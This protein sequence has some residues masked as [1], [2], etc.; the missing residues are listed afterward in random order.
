[1]EDFDTLGRIGEGAHGIV[2]KAKHLPV[3]LIKNN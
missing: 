2:F 3:R 1:M